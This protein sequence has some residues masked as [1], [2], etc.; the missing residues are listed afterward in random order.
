[1]ALIDDV[2]KVMR[3]TNTAHDT[4]LTDLINAAIADLKLTGITAESA[5]T[6]DTLIKRAVMI[7]VKTN[8]G[9]DNTDMEK[10]QKS[11]DLLKWHLTLSGDY[12]FYK[13]NFVVNDGTS[14]VRARV[15]LDNTQTNTN[16][17][18]E[19][20]FYMLKKNNIKYTITSEGFKTVTETID[21]N[22]SKTITVSLILV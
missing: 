2:K 21:I 11:Y 18:G 19:I 4:E 5:V 3:I 13:I 1:M 6:T 20:S 10:L 22:Q 17:D 8:F 15:T 16:E 7:Y 12:S 14:G 9:W